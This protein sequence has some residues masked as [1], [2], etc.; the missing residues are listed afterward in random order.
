MALKNKY[1]RSVALRCATCG[2]THAFET[3]DETGVITCNKC[4]HVYQG[5]KEELIRLNE[6]HI[7]EEKRQIV[8]DVQKD[9]EKEI[10]KLFKSLKFGN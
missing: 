7:E 9:A 2:A 1:D 3:N 8:K 10:Q 6:A 5:G 4:K